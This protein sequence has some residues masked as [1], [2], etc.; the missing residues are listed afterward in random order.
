MSFRGNLSDVGKMMTF[1][2]LEIDPTLGYI[3]EIVAQRDGDPRIQNHMQPSARLLT[4][5]M[6]LSAS[7]LQ[8]ANWPPEAYE[9]DTPAVYDFPRENVVQ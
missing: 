3:P 9:F 7:L 8:Y 1:F 6:W 5:A 2:S 4:Y